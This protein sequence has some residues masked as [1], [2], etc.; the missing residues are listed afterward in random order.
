MFVH[1]ST[2][3]PALGNLTTAGTNLR[4]LDDSLLAH[5]PHRHH[6]RPRR[7]RLVHEAKRR[8]KVDA[9]RDD[10]HL[11]RAGGGNVPSAMDGGIGTPLSG[12]MMCVKDIDCSASGKA[13]G[14]DV[15]NWNMAP[16]VCVL[17][18]GGDPGYC[19]AT[20]DCWCAGEDATCNAA[21]HHCSFTKH[22]G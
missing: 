12:G 9:R 21:T 3:P 2:S 13:C 1:Q 20:G 6:A 11:Q 16:H 4:P 8:R 19:N 18:V 10:H 5:R 7:K 17:A 14:G 22:G 15:C